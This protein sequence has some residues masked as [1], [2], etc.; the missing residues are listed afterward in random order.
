MGDAY[1]VDACAV[2]A[3]HSESNTLA[4][5]MAIFFAVY[6]AIDTIVAAAV[7]ATK[8]REGRV[9]RVDRKSQLSP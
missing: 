8:T 7:V 4:I 5:T 6:L 9:N 1:I 2:A 3:A